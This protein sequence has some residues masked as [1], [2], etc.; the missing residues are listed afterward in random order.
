ME[1]S[2][3]TVSEVLQTALGMVQL[4]CYKTQQSINPNKILIT[5]F[6]K[7]R[8]IRAS[9]VLD[10][11][12]KTIQL[13]YL[14]KYPGLTWKMQLGKVANKAYPAFRTSTGMIGKM[15]GLRPDV[16]HHSGKLH[17]HVCCDYVLTMGEIHNRHYWT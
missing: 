9:K 8:D 3:H 15:W 12:G 11:G 5:P 4:W 6:T 1:N 13:L 14:L 7:K 2:S 17:D 16:L 10:L